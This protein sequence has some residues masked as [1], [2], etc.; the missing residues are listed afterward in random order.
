[1][2]RGGNE[3]KSVRPTLAGDAAALTGSS[4]PPASPAA[5]RANAAIAS[6]R[7]SR[8]QPAASVNIT[9]M[10]SPNHVRDEEQRAADEAWLAASGHNLD[11]DYD[12]HLWLEDIQGNPF[13]TL[14]LL[15]SPSLGAGDASLAWVRTQ[16]ED[17]IEKLGNP[18]GSDRYNRIL[19]ILNSQH[20]IPHVRKIG[21]GDEVPRYY[22]VAVG[23]WVV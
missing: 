6:A 11:P 12:E 9:D 22:W 2:L 5:Y 18:E 21:A 8:P 15:A 20:K 4:T 13:A 7:F 19:A 16:N 14:L 17:C 1:M 23:N 3:N 10:L